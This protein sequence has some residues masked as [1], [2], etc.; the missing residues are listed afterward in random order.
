VLTRAFTPG[1]SC[2]LIDDII[3]ISQNRA[4]FNIYTISI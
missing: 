3:M 2:H 4:G 1:L